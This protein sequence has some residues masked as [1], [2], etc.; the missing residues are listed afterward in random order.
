M[1]TSA[2]A[3]SSAGISSRVAPKRRP[4]APQAMRRDASTSRAREVIARVQAR[5]LEQLV[6]VVEPASSAAARADAR[7]ALPT[8]PP[9]RGEGGDGGAHS[10]RAA[11]RM[12]SSGGSTARPAL[13]TRGRPGARAARGRRRPARRP[14]ARPRRAESASR[15]RGRRNRR[16][17]PSDSTTSAGTG[18][19]LSAAMPPTGVQWTS[20]PAASRGHGGRRADLAPRARAPRAHRPGGRPPRRGA[21]RRSGGACRRAAAPSPRRGRAAAGADHDA[22]LAAPRRAPRRARGRRSDRRA[23]PPPAGKLSVLTAPASSASGPSSSHSASAAVL[24]GTVTLAPSKPSAA[25]PRTA[26][27]QVGG[28]DAQRDVDAIE[29]ERRRGGVVHARRARVLDRVADHAG[30]ARR[31]ADG[32]AG[33]VCWKCWK[34]A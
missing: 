15:R 8:P 25:R 32:H 18:S 33:C 31:A 23:A 12:T 28:R 34:S 30:D 13:G 21:R 16:R 6:G 10:P 11:R 20:S 22:A 5:L 1:P 19:C 2:N 17:R 7:R 4:A 3:S 27:R 14:P 26:V 24:C 9:T 29:A